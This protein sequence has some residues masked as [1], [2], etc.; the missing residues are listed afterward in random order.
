MKAL[1]IL[2]FV[3]KSLILSCVVASIANANVTPPPPKVMTQAK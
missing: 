3:A 1:H 2:K